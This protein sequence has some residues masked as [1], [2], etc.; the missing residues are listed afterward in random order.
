[1]KA[2]QAG[3]DT[4]PLAVAQSLAALLDLNG[5]D[6]AVMG[7]F[8]FRTEHTGRIT[9]HSSYTELYDEHRPLAL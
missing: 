3:Q 9:D 7:T 6:Q 5:Q 1:M 4:P 8:V 2:G